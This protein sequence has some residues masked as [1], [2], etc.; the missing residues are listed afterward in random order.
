M[1][2]L[3][4]LET[5]QVGLSLFRLQL[6]GDH[7]PTTI[8]HHGIW[9]AILSDG[10]LSTGRCRA[11]LSIAIPIDGALH[12]RSVGVLIAL[13]KARKGSLCK[14]TPAKIQKAPAEVSESPDEQDNFHEGF[15]AVVSCRGHPSRNA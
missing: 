12:S 13:A 11:S 9:F 4:S 8:S 14:V 1:K 2:R 15:R 10:S 5:A 6:A 3:G 7:L